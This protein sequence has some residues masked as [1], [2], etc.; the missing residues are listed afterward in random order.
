MF[1][2]RY[3]KGQFPIVRQIGKDIVKDLSLV[4][5]EGEITPVEIALYFRKYALRYTNVQ[6]FGYPCKFLPIY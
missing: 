3:I 6:M 2:L 5:N 4:L 1:Y